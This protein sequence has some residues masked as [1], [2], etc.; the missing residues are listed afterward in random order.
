MGPEATV[1]FMD[2]IIKATPA[3]DDSDHIHMLVDNNPQIP[4]RVKAILEAGE[5]P[6]PVMAQMARQLE[7]WGADFIAIPCNTAHFYY[8]EVK[9]AVKIPV[10]NIIQITKE[11]ILQEI[12]NVK[13]IGL[14]AT[15]AVLVTRLYHNAFQEHSVD[16]LTPDA[17]NQQKVMDLIFA[18]KSNQYSAELIKELQQIANE[19]I[20]EGAQAIIFGCTELS[21]LAKDIHNIAVPTFDPSQILAEEVIHIVKG[22]SNVLNKN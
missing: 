5:S 15:T 14:L 2:K 1:D 3:N 4:S 6:G 13:K 11:K 16:I 9:S 8:L 12:P 19:L 20:K 7:N 21:V 18:V 10:L 17:H 22:Q